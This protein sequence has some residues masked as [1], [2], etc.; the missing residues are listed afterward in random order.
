MTTLNFKS[1]VSLLSDIRR[2]VVPY[3]VESESDLQMYYTAILELN[4]YTAYCQ[5]GDIQAQVELQ[6][7]RLELRQLEDEYT[8]YISW[9]GLDECPDEG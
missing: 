9:D 2:I 1:N 8:S 7:K 6:K 5:P 4:D 3:C